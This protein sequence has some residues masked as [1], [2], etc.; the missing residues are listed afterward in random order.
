MGTL[1]TW[2]NIFLFVLVAGALWYIYNLFKGT[3]P[4][5]ST[6]VTGAATWWKAK[7]GMAKSGTVIPDITGQAGANADAAGFA[8]VVNR[9]SQ[10]FYN[11]CMSQY[12]GDNNLG[13][14]LSA[15]GTTNWPWKSYDDWVAA[16]QPHL[17]GEEAV[18]ADS[19]GVYHND[20]I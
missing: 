18:Y 11:A 20:Y 10:G 6:L 3:A 8:S 12:A 4:K 19:N 7:F 15:Q 17:P 2:M 16:G 13:D 9:F 5:I 14:T 1:K